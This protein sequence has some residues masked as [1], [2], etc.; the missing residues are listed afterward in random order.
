MALNFPNAPTVGQL[1]PSPAVAGV[2]VYR[3]DGIA[4]TSSGAANDKQAVYSDGSVPMIGQLKLVGDPVALLDAADKNYVD[5]AIAAVARNGSVAKNANY[6][7]VAADYGKLFKL[8]GG[9]TLAL[10]AA[11]TLGDGFWFEVQ[12]D[13][14]GIFTIDPNASETID[15]ALTQ[16]VLRGH[17]FKV[18]CDGAGW[19]TVGRQSV[20]RF[21][22]NVASA[23]GTLVV[24]PLPAGYSK[25]RFEIS[26]ITGLAAANNL[27]FTASVD[28]GA[29]F[30]NSGYIQNRIYTGG[31]AASGT[32]NAAYANDV[33]VVFLIGNV[34][35][36][37]PGGLATLEIAKVDQSGIAH[38][39]TFIQGNPDNSAG[40][41]MMF[42]AGRIGGSTSP[43]THIRFEA[44][45]GTFS[46]TINAYG[47]E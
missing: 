31:T 25:I 34:N 29:T 13:D 33:K 1:Y 35:A 7:V 10:T 40:T 26:D 22:K 11:A 30:L 15:G 37:V 21:S 39:F 16:T 41:E 24:G 14:N 44:S 20:V 28:G 27:N 2:P 6:T 38:S 18:R 4:W 42:C 32:P 3:W 5:N 23:V 46:G 47:V 43:I 45:A 12:S 17:R 19:Y 36:G 8:S 9:A